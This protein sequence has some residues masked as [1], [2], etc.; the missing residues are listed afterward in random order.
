MPDKSGLLVMKANLL[1]RLARVA[2]KK[3]VLLRGIKLRN[4]NR[5]LDAVE[6]ILNSL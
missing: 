2:C 6:R 3:F 5:R 4:I 1:G